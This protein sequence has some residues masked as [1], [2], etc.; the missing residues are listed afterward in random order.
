M[1]YTTRTTTGL[2]NVHTRETPGPLSAAADLLDGIGSPGDQVW[3]ADRW[4]AMELDRGLQ[5]D[6][7]G[8]HGPIRY[9]VESVVPGRSVVFRFDEP[10]V[11]THSLSIEP[12]NGERVRWTHVVDV[13]KPSAAQKAMI[14]PMHDACLEDLL[15]QVEAKQSGSPVVR[16]RFSPKV[17][18]LLAAERVLDREREPE[19]ELARRRPL[20]WSA[21]GILGALSAAHLLWGLGSSWPLRSR[22]ALARTVGG[23]PGAVVPGLGACGAVAGAL[24]AAG[25]LTVSRVATADRARIPTGVSHLGVRVVSGVLALRGAFGFAQSGLSPNSVTPEFR[26]L[27]LTAYSPLCLVLAAVLKRVSSGGR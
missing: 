18:F 8:G 7:S 17:R 22:E 14:I 23:T 9:H 25:G 19:T 11:G 26:R 5:V 2:R 13:E 12:V 4:P 16:R 24:A 6:S 10:L 27:D 20:A 3:P 1:T 21:A 15:D